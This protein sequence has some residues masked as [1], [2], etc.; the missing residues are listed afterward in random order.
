MNE[1]LINCYQD[2]VKT[3]YQKLKSCDFRFEDDSSKLTESDIRTISTKHGLT[4]D[5]LKNA[6]LL[7]PY[8]PDHYR[9]MHFDLIFRAVNARAATWS[10]KIPLEFRIPEP[11]EDFIPSFDEYPI[12]ELESIVALDK[13]LTQILIK[14]LIN[15]NKYKGFAYHQL[16]YLNKIFHE[17]LKCYL[18][19]SP[20]ASG[21]SLIF[22]LTIL[23][24]ILKQI[25]VKGTKAMVIYPRK[26]LASDQL[27]KFLEIIHE[28]NKLLKGKGYPIIKVGID[29]GDTPRSDTS[30]Q[31]K[32]RE[33]FRGI[34]CISKKCNGSL[35]YHVKKNRCIIMCDRCGKVYEEIV[36]TK[37]EIW[38]SK[39][40]IIFSNLSAINRRLMM[41]PAKDIFG[42]TL[43]WIVLDEAH[44][45]REERGGHARWLLRRLLARVNLFSKQN[46]RLIISSATIYN[47]KKFASKLTGLPENE[48][49][50][51]DYEKIIAK[52][53]KKK[54]KLTLNLIIAPNPWRSAESLCEEL[55][56]LLGVWSYANNKKT[57]VFVDNVSEVE[58]L[59]DF[60]VNT[61]ILERDAH[62]DH[63]DPRKTPR[64]VDV[65]YPFSWKS[66][67]NGLSNIPAHKLAEIY[68]YHYGE[69]TAEQRAKIEE[70]FKNSKCGV[71]FCTSTLELGID[72]GDI[73]AIIQYKVPL[74]SESYVQRVGR[75]GRTDEVGRI[76]LGILILTNSPNQIMYMLEG[77][78]QRL[79]N[80]QVEIPI[81]WENEEIKKQHIMF[82]LLDFLAANGKPTFLDF[83]GEVRGRWLNL[84]GALVD[85][86]RLI[87]DL[88]RSMHDFRR[89]Q[90][91]VY[92]N[93]P[94]ISR[95]TEG[96]L[97]EIEKKINFGLTNY[98]KLHVSNV[99]AELR[100]FRAMEDELLKWKQTIEST[101]P[102]IKEFSQSLGIREVEEYMKRVDELYRSLTE[103][104]I[105]LES[106]WG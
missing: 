95:E 70:Q 19:V 103:L 39:P 46:V 16:Y 67:V 48:I 76:A 102:K 89:Y 87:E 79:L 2:L 64:I 75:A 84:K 37:E 93:D 10:P 85:L 58:R 21:K 49:Y 14:A 26:A 98:E 42:G 38:N 12:S 59:R 74:T 80:P 8:S 41:S 11:V 77:E 32:N 92:G 68:G 31:V 54:R 13:E 20:T 9:T 94:L 83:V 56:L 106:L 7:V 3:E 78:Y 86:K 18:I 35:I 17:N 36:P 43:E 57:L 6:E 4:P 72:I 25:S 30:R 82:S 47:P 52:S 71:L 81:A 63:I 23:V 105:S 55:A 51:E 15:L 96:I 29:D 5:E 91:K 27:M 1:T 73:A 66:L 101:F 60:V 99:G 65:S 97:S 69:L 104:L 44:V 22:F 28:V 50:Y 53:K 33:V 34:K 88:K 61:I 62:N 100:N 90:V 24:S 45:Y 40:D